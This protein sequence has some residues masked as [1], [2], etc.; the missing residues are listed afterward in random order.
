MDAE[1]VALA[2]AL[3]EVLDL[4]AVPFSEP[5]HAATARVVAPAT[6][7]SARVSRCLGTAV[8]PTAPVDPVMLAIGYEAAVRVESA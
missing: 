3:D 1:G 5:P 7:T 2:V 6:A 8:N 4:A